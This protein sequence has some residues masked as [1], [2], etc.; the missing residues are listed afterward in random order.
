MRHFKAPALLFVVALLSFYFVR[1]VLPDGIQQP[2]HVLG[3][4]TTN[5]CAKINASG[6]LVTNAA[7]CAASGGGGITVYSG[8]GLTL[9]AG[10]YYFPVGGGATPSVTETSVDVEAPSA[11]TITNFYAQLSVT[12]GAGQTGVFTWRKAGVSQSVTCTV[13]GTATTCND[14]THSFTV[15]QG[16]LIDIQLVTTGTVVATPNLIMAAQFGTT[17]SNGTVNTGTIGQC[18][19]YATT[20]TAISGQPCGAGGSVPPQTLT[21]CT[22]AS[23]S[24]TTYTCTPSPAL[25]SYTAGDLITFIPQTSNT[26]ASTVNISALG[27]KSIIAANTTGSA[28]VAD[29]L[30]GAGV[31]VLEYDGTNFRSIKGPDG[32]WTALSYSNSW[33]NFGGGFQVGQY[34]KTFDGY[35][36]VRG[37]LSA[38][39]LTA[40]TVVF[41]LPAGYR[42]ASSIQSL[43]F[44]TE[45]NGNTNGI[46]RV[47]F[48]TNGQASLA[49][50]L[51]G[52]TSIIDL[53]SQ[54]SV[55]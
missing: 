35:V 14:L 42:P 36:H 9:T 7:T 49:H 22:D 52:L 46:G 1:P 37:I 40:G 21:L 15:A 20:G 39:T 51:V 30:L 13:S 34:Q 26:G 2:A 31:Y 41:T 28:L 45:T 24:T 19:F 8:T 25:G 53:G 12:L 54:F 11:A 6:F 48:A 5:D 10:T 47:D 4:F 33:S 44:V 55:Y 3:A 17:G 16:D 18:G 32:A 27:A 38:G 29:D 23:G 43:P 50:S